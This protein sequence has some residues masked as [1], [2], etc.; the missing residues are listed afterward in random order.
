MT[1]VAKGSVA[2]KAG[3]DV[4]DVITSLKRGRLPLNIDTPTP[5]SLERALTSYFPPDAIRFEVLTDGSEGELTI[6][7]VR[8][9]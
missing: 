9:P 4:G 7:R 5:S 6:R 3:F 8:L 1:S 2:A